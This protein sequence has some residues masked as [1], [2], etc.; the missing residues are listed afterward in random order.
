MRLITKKLL[1]FFPFGLMMLTVNGLFGQDTVK[2]DGYQKF[3]YQ[4][5]ILS[6]EGTMKKGQ[7]DG[8]WKSYFDNGKLKSEGN[9]L[10]YE[11]DSTWKFYNEEGKLT[12]EINYAKGKKNGLKITYLDRETVKENFRN[13]IKE[14]YTRIYYPEGGLKMEIPFV[15][16]LEQGTGK[17]YSTEGRIITITEYKKGFVTDRM[18]VNRTDANNLK[19]GTWV[20]FHPNGKLSREGTYRD[21]KKNGYFKDYAENGDLLKITKYIDDVIQPDA[22]EIQKLEVVNDYYPDGTVKSTSMYRNGIP[23][24][25]RKDYTTEGKIEKATEY[26]N[27]A[28]IGEGIVLEDGSKDGPWKE[29][30]S[31][32]A[33]R[34][35]GKYEAGKPVGEWKYYHPNGK[36][37]QQGKYNKQGKP[38][39]TWRWYYDNGQLLRE[40]AYYGGKQDGLSEEYDEN[41]TL[42]EKG[43]YLD[44]LEDGPWVFSL[45]DYAYRGSY[46]DGLRTGPWF[47]YYLFPNGTKTD[48][49]ISFQGSFIDD[50]P[51]GKQVSYW[52]NGKIREEGT[53]VMGRKEGDWMQYNYDG[54]LFLI[55]TYQNGIEVRYDG[56]KIKPPFEREE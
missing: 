33:L 46:R 22:I 1:L 28:I 44:G 30:Y 27:G 2:A 32:G 49:I 47:T 25:I 56:I 34:A 12:L 5:G 9:R 14:G 50:L 35:E 37:E 11:L 20:S 6:S 42:I 51:D 26:R 31:D 54:T 48:S 3:Y 43:E 10:N 18:K 17:E 24:G 41:G 40:E 45:G 19:Q 15:K 52:E 38:D 8:Y 13:D 36:I 16:G 55:I 4:N 23:E 7:P 29:F 39:G 21:D 53:Y